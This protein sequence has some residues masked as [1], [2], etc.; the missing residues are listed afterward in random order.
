[1]ISNEILKKKI[2]VELLHLEDKNY[3]NKKIIDVCTLKSGKTPKVDETND[4]GE[5][6][7]YKVS[8]MN[9]LGNE[10]YM[11]VDSLFIVKGNY[12]L[13]P[14]NSIIF[15]KNGGALLTNKKRILTKESLVDLN[16]G[17][18]IPS[19]II[20]YKY[21]YYIMLSI[22]FNNYYKGTALPTLDSSKFLDINI[23]V[24]TKE[25]QQKIID[26]IDYLFKLIEKKEYNDQE[27]S[28][29]K[30]VLKEKILDSAI[31]GTLVNNDLNLNSVDLKETN[32]EIPFE[33]PKNWKWAKMENCFTFKQGVQIDVSL[34]KL[35][36]NT[37]YPLRFLRIVD[38][39]QNNSDIRYVSKEYENWF[40]NENEVAIV[41][42]GASAGFICLGKSGVLA[43]NLFK[44]IPIVDMDEKYTYYLLNSNYF[45]KKIRTHSVAMPALKFASLNK[46]LLPIP[47]LVEQK[48]IAKKIENLFELIEQL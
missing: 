17:V 39:T 44:L 48:R 26:K 15:P 1:M 9:V 2:L 46:I 37:N 3:T 29:L 43:N 24:P 41:R 47:P 25:I 12:Q 45:Q 16:T 6:P 8:D 23:Y 4:N 35:E 30:N 5:I 22:D 28:Q 34:Q 33:I 18:L 21:L 13:F 19:D 36:Q 42:Y 40:M 7:Y 10:V 31:H 11:S 27:K 20:C 32:V 14:K 38:F